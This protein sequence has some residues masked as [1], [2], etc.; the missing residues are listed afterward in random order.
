MTVVATVGTTHPLGIAGL[1]FAQAVLL[2][3]GVRPVCVVAGVSAQ[4][5]TRVLGVADVAPALIA[6]QFEALDAASVAAFH[7]GAL[8]SARAVHAVSAG[9]ARFPGVPVVVD[10]VRAATGGDRLADDPTLRAM[11][12]ELFRRATLV[13]PN[14]DEAEALLDAPVRDVDAMHGACERLRARYGAA[15]VLVKGGHLSGEAVDVLGDAHGTRAFASPRAAGELRGTGDMLAATI[16][17]RLAEGASL[18]EAIQH[19]RHRVR[20]AIAR[21]T[22]FAGTRVASW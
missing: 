19:A 7:V 16:A 11:C 5:A 8:V 15:A 10:P 3:D 20:E 21:G 17:A 22:P 14:L 9:L 6:A 12:D 2:H 4:D 18:G 13:T 1:T